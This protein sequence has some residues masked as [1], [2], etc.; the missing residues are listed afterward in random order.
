MT[1]THTA[2]I[3]L[4]LNEATAPQTSMAVDAM[5]HHHFKHGRHLGEFLSKN[6]CRMLVWVALLVAIA[7]MVYLFYITMDLQ[8]HHHDVSIIQVGAHYRCKGTGGCGPQ[9]PFVAKDDPRGEIKVHAA[10]IDQIL[11]KMRDM[12]KLA[13]SSVQEDLNELTKPETLEMVKGQLEAIQE[14]QKTCLV[15]VVAANMTAQKLA[16]AVSSQDQITKAIVDTNNRMR[17]LDAIATI[18]GMAFS[19]LVVQMGAIITMNRMQDI[20]E[21]D[22]TKVANFDEKMYRVRAHVMDIKKIVD[23]SIV[24]FVRSGVSVDSPYN[25][26]LLAIN[27]ADSDAEAVVVAMVFFMNAVEDFKTK[28][29]EVV[30]K[31]NSIQAT[32]AKCMQTCEGFTNSLP[33]KVGS[34]EIIALTASGNYGDALMKIALEDEVAINHRKFAKE[35]S[36]F[37]SGGGVPSVLDHDN[38]VNPWVGIFGRPDYRKR[39]GKSA[40]EDNKLFPLKQIPSDDPDQIM[41]ERIPRLSFA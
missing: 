22:Q 14:K 23:D 24:P 12:Q 2:P 18:Q 36:S 15:N 27:A 3:T 38:D 26:N 41:R 10:Q 13:E 11:T 40:E 17:A 19:A 1:D 34:E 5:N 30:N 32:F 16:A 25:A 6:W 29:V 8:E 33:N 20:P 4:N 31:H 9:C 28:V 37:D 21:M 39:N 35:R 7:F